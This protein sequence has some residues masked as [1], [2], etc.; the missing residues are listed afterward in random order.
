MTSAAAVSAALR[1]VGFNPLGSGT[2]RTRE[3]IRVTGSS[4]ERV[5]VVADLDSERAAV[6]LAIAARQALIGAGYSVD[7]STG[8]PA[9]FYVTR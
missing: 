7:T 9:A 6:D 4:L 8:D 1:R 5:R 2:P 3:G